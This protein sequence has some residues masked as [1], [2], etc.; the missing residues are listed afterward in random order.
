MLTGE[1]D[2]AVSIEAL[3]RGAADYLMKRRIDEDRL[4]R[5]VRGAIER[6]TLARQVALQ[7]QRLSRFYRLA[8]QTEDALFIVEADTLRI[9][10][11][12]EAA[13]RRLGVQLDGAA[14]SAPTADTRLA[15]PQ[16]RR[17]RRSR[18]AS[19]SASCRKPNKYASGRPRTASSCTSTVTRRAPGRWRA[20]RDCDHC[21]W[22]CTA[23]RQLHRSKTWESPV[24]RPLH[25]PRRC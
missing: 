5:A 10:D 12:N 19:H 24:S 17:M 22:R 9:S 13:R 4:L 18:C 7:Q 1:E 16:N 14:Q 6:A 3:R 25:W 2:A 15:T 11:G 23:P 21:A 8:N 20:P